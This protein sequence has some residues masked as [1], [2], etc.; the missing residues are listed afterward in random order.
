MGIQ[1]FIDADDRPAALLRFVERLLQ[2]ADP[3][4]AVVGPLALSVGVVHIR[5]NR[6]PR[7]SGL[8]VIG[9]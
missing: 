8:T 2:V 6:A 4:L 3:R 1:K 7:A 9:L 5:Q